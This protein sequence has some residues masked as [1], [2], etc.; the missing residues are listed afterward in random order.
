MTAI[1]KNRKALKSIQSTSYPKAH[2][3]RHPVVTVM[4]G[5]PFILFG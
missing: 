4:M 1:Y 2:A 5:K 3:F